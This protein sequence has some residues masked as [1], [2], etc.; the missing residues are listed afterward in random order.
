MEY[1]VQE[2]LRQ[3]T[4]NSGPFVSVEE[5]SVKFDEEVQRILYKSDHDT[6]VIYILGIEGTNITII[7]QRFFPFTAYKVP[8]PR[9]MAGI[10]AAERNEVARKNKKRKH[11]I[12][13][14]GHSDGYF[15]PGGPGYVEPHRD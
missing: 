12:N 6:Q 2:K 15:D 1:W 9:E 10:R 5:A 14:F 11:W 7:H 8:S 13:Q 4:Q 3:G